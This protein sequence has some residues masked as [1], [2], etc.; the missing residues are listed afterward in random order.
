MYSE[1][2]ILR[3]LDEFAAREGWMPT[4]HTLDQVDEF[5]HYIDSLVKIETNSRS[6]Y[7][8]L[9]RAITQKRQK[10]IWRWIEN[11]QALAL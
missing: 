7:I 5:K 11:E 6:S 4:P 2:I 9:V 8:T 1:K 3:N 10:E